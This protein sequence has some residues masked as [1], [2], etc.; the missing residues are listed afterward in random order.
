MEEANKTRLLEEFRAYLD[1]FD[2]SEQEDK[3]QTDLFTLFAELA[4]LRTEVK[5]ESRLIGAALDQFKESQSLLRSSHEH[6][7]R[8]LEKSRNELQGA[9][10]AILRPQLLGLLELHDRLSAGQNALQN[11]HPVK[12]WFR[13]KSRREDRLFIQSIR[14]G[15]AMTLRRL[16]ETLSRHHV[17]PLEVLGRIVDPHAM[18]VVE[19]DHRIVGHMN[20]RVLAREV[21][22]IGHEKL[23]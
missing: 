19:L 5:T 6:L 3:E 17:R 21:E 7:E 2:D 22:E 11:Y 18:T 8:E 12:G 1:G 16:D 20:E 13:I 23:S 10:R 15:Q 4:A 14:E 9:R